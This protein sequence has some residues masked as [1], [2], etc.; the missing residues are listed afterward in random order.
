MFLKRITNYLF[1]ML[2]LIFKSSF[3][4][5]VVIISAD[6]EYV[7]GAGESM[8][9]SEEKAKKI[10]IQKA[11]EQAGVYV[12]SYTKVKNL[13][14]ESDVIEV[15]ANHS[16]KIEVVDKKKTVVGDLDAIKFYVKIKA[17]LSQEDIATN[18]KKI[19]HDQKIVDDY[20]R[21]KVD[22]EKQ[23][24][25]VER[26]KRQLEIATGGDKQRIAKL[27]SEEEKKYKAIL[28]LERAQSLPI[29][30]WNIEEKLKALEKVLE[31]NP[32]I[33]QAYLGIAEVLEN[34]YL[35]EPSDDKE[36]E[37][38]LDALRD[39]VEHLNRALSLDENYAEAYAY[40][41]EI[42]YKI[43]QLEN[44]EEDEK[45]YNTKILKDINRALALNAKDKSKLYYL[46]ST[47]YLE[48]L[49][50]IE[51]E[52]ERKDK[53]DSKIIEEQFNKAINEIDLAGSLC[54]EKDLWCLVEYNRRKAGAYS[55][56]IQYYQISGNTAKVDEY[57]L[58]RNKF[59][60]K[61]SVF[62]E[63][64][65]KGEKQGAEE[66]EE[67]LLEDFY[68]TEY[69]KIE[70]ELIHMG[71]REKATGI[72]DKVLKEKNE[73]EQEKIFKEVEARISK[74]ISTGTASAEE[75]IFMSYVTENPQTSRNYFEKGVALYEKRQPQGLDALLLTKFYLERAGMEE[76]SDIA[77]N[78]LN[79]AK[80]IIVKHLPQAEK[81]MSISEALLLASEMEKGERNIKV[82]KR[83][84]ALN[85]Q[86]AEAFW[87]YAF[88]ISTSNKAAE[89]YERLDLPLKARE[90]Y[91]YL[92]NTFKYEEACKNAERLKN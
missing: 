59:S 45:E 5:E 49:Q 20:N 70:Y 18:L 27:I 83:I 30:E 64:Y 4:S 54:N 35:G 43:K 48:E 85:K 36:K 17:T 60:Q 63:Q 32:D 12:K 92:C 11:A 66:G 31:L 76:N 7:M 87:W 78:Y 40:R 3:A 25:E 79:K 51:M 89:I 33:P 50:N 68:N 10:A 71:W 38:I 9:V 39:A 86:Q 47:I 16:M 61:A 28:W 24:K 37:D 23:N 73:E 14:L 75:Y 15:I 53:Y 67:L 34:K 55:I 8:E 2:L 74:K 52:Q 65:F 77:L 84:F 72:T 91:L 1:L 62:E 88:A 80:A 6:G 81:A 56:I 26:L 44:S 13:A 22:F 58:I 57:L 82:L 69:G 46:R 90:E 21:L 29:N 41:A 42:L 19:M